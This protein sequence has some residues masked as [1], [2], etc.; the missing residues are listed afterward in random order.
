MAVT[1]MQGDS[2]PIFLNLVQDGAV[3]VPDMV[4]DLEI[5]VG[6]GLRFSYASGTVQYDNESARWYIWPTQEN[7]FTLEEGSYKVEV[8]IKYKNQNTTNVNG[9][10]LDDKI[11]VRGANSREVL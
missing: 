3:L 7:T 10:T 6:E 2:F 1:I 4:D 9:F 11:K 8:R 5:Y